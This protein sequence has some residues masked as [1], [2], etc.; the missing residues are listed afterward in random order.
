MNYF[1]LYDLPISFN[2]D[3]QLV[4][5]KFYQLSK[6]YH[7]DFYVNEAEAKQEEVLAMATLNNKAYQVFTNP[8]KLLHYI[9]TLKN[10]L[11]EGENYALTPAFLMEMMEVNEVLMDLEL[12]PDSQKLISLTEELTKLSQ[13]LFNE[14][15][16]L[17]L[18]FNNITLSQQAANLKVIKEIYYRNKYIYR[19]KETIKRLN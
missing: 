1:E 4:K 7:P 18:A 14:L 11:T 12:A 19:L 16:T 8:Q 10:C 15:A 17:T 9:L 13:K 6:K 2:P 3:P 5:Q